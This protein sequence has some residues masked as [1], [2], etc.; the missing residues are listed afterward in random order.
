MLSELE[1]RLELVD[2]HRKNRLK[3]A[4][5][6]INNPNYFNELIEFSF[7]VTNPNS[8]KGCWVLE[9]VAYKELGWFVDYLEYFCQ[10]L[11][12]LT[13]ESSIRPLA[14]VTQLL[15]TSHYSKSKSIISLSESQLQNCIEISFDWLIND[16][17]V[18][19]KAYCIRT[20]YLLG[21][22]YNWIHPELKIILDKDYILHSAAYKAVAREV[23]KKIK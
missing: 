5:F 17:K 7:V 10:N 14:K 2:G 19:T 6:V 8:Y 22:H 21:K 16:S 1:Q 13:N 9:F 4:E 3:T 20:L 18:A 23:L 15:L 12:I 11:K